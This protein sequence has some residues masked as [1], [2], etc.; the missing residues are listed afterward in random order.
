MSWVIRIT[1]LF[2]R[3]KYQP[4]IELKLVTIYLNDKISVGNALTF[5]VLMCV[6]SLA[7]IML[8]HS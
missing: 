1:F 5:L 8:K 7:E 3:L 4:V 2:S 6:D